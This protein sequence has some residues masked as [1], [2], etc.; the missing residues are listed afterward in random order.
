MKAVAALK[1][2]ITITE[3]EAGP[4]PPG[5][6]RVRTEY[7]AISPGTEMTFIRRAS[8]QLAV[9]GY[10]A[11]GIV[12]EAGA[13]V[14]H[15]QVGQRVAC[16]GAP[17]VRHAERLTVPT[18]LTA[19]VP[20]HVQ[21][22]DAAFAGLGAIAIHALRTADLRFGESAIIVG[23]GILGQ[24]IARIASAAAYRVAGFDTNPHRA[25]LLRQRGVECA[26]DNQAQLEERLAELTGGH[27]ADSVILCAGGPGEELIDSSLRWIRDRGKIVIVGDLSTSFSRGLMFGKE[28]Q[29]LISR[30]GGPGRYDAGYELENKDYPIGFVRW[31]EGRN[32]AEYIRLLAENQISLEGLI[33]DTYPMERAQEAYEGYAQSSN[34]MGTLLSYGKTSS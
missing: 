23:L 28:A 34:R 22:E 4:V 19:A 30:A 16:Y 33:S 24:L 21:P 12:E 8:E 14:R 27:G 6:V 29:V 5:H 25:E 3:L 2:K 11:V 17:Y 1:G 9:L 20:P 32:I 13:D 7:S 10:S 18:N 31:T 26:V 15:L